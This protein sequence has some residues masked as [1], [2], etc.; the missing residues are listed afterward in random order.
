[1]FVTKSIPEQRGN[2]YVY[3]PEGAYRPPRISG[4]TPLARI[5]GYDIDKELIYSIGIR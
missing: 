1:M 3:S 4:L 5:S 2:Q